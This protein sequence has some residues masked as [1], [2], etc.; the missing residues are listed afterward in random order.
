MDTFIIFQ[1]FWIKV[2]SNVCCLLVLQMVPSCF[3]CPVLSLVRSGRH[4]AIIF[5]HVALNY[6]DNKS[7]CGGYFRCMDH[8]Q[9]VTCSALQN[10]TFQFIKSIHTLV[11]SLIFVYFGML[12]NFP[13][14]ESPIK[15]CHGPIEFGPLL[16]LYNVFLSRRFF[17]QISVL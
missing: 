1:M 14:C 9:I 12:Y 13:T 6:A 11:L 10:H 3:Y 7:L 8:M 2:W 17:F 15:I 5:H 16:C 4:N